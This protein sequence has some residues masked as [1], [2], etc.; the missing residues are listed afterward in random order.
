MKRVGI[1][2]VLTVIVSFIQCGR[3][4]NSEYKISDIRKIDPVDVTNKMN[5]W[6]TDTIPLNNLQFKVT[7]KEDILVSNGC[8]S[9]SNMAYATDQC[10]PEL[11]LWNIDSIA[12]FRKT[13][14]EELY[15]SRNF[16][17]RIFSVHSSKN[18]Q[19]P[20]DSV[21]NIDQ[22]YIEH[23][24]KLTL[25]PDSIPTHEKYQFLFKFYRKNAKVI[26]GESRPIFITD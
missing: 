12:V 16:K 15:F 2:F 19:L 14:S 5:I 21:S 4:E 13:S 23:P 6:T 10:P 1:L 24:I 7:F 9:F 25:R 18:I 22:K 26:E 3:C 11:A 17:L 20:L 8:Y